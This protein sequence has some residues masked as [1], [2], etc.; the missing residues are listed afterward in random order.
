M[1]VAIFLSDI[2]PQGRETKEKI[3]KWDYIKLKSFCTAKEIINKIK[4]QPKE[5][6][7]IFVN[8]SDKGFISKIYNILTKLNT[9]KRNNPIKKWAKN[10]NM[11]FSKEDIQMANRQKKRCSMPLIIREI[12]IKTTMRYNLIP[13]RMAVINKSTN[14]KCW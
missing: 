5:W 12:Q 11:H 8:V 13:L 4:R 1:L 3:S 7:N 14:N 9:K 6:E 10:L 2:S